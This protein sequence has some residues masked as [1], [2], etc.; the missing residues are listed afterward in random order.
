MQ[1]VSLSDSLKKVTEIFQEAKGKALIVLSEHSEITGS[2]E[3][4]IAS[5][6]DQLCTKLGAMGGFIGTNTAKVEFEPI[7]NFMG[8]PIERVAVVQSEDLTPSEDQLEAFRAKVNNLIEQIDTLAPEGILNAYTTPEDQ[9]ILRGAAKLVGL[10][11]YEEAEINEQFVER[12]VKGKEVM[13]AEKKQQ[14]LIDKKLEL[15]EAKVKLR[16]EI[17][18]QEAS[19]A[20]IQVDLETAE[21]AYDESKPNSKGSKA[22]LSLKEDLEAAKKSLEVTKEQLKQLEDTNAE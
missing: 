16:E 20:E 8:E 12:I 15:E 17:E 4:I 22:Y 21:K 5:N 6:I 10:E 7:T 1:E 9:L 3:I 13:A 14:E 2:L 19:V 11:D 18:R